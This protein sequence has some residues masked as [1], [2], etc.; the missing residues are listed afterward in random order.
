VAF[1]AQRAPDEIEQTQ[2]IIQQGE[3]FS[4]C[5]PEN[6]P[7]K[8]TEE[9]IAAAEIGLRVKLPASLLAVLKMQNGGYPY[10]STHHPDSLPLTELYGIAPGCTSL[11][12]LQEM[13]E[14][15]WD[16]LVADLDEAIY[17]Q[18]RDMFEGEVHAD[19]GEGLKIPETILLLCDDLHWGIA[20]N[21]VR[22]GREGEPSVVH[23]EMECLNTGGEILAELAPDFLTFIKMLD[24]D[25]ESDDPF[26]GQQ[27]S[28]F[29][30]FETVAGEPCRK[31]DCGEDR[32]HNGVY[33]RAHHY[34]MTFGQ[35]P[36]R[37]Q[38]NAENRSGESDV[39]W[40]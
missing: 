40:S 39:D 4:W 10:K 12:S 21:Y 16:I 14:R 18:W 24:K 27:W 3:L 9:M 15:I 5:P 38:T 30:N 22:C 26:L 33:C 37:Q 1:V 2:E 23:V 20:L 11:S 32:I 25:D 36:P 31:P 17:Q 35:P 34:E 13:P 8:L 19:W 7:S 29:K 28:E 6:Q